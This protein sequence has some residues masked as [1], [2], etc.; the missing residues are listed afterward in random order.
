MATKAK[1]AN[2]CLFSGKPVRGRKARFL[3]GYDAKMKS[4]LLKVSRGQEKIAAVPKAALDALKTD[5]LLGFRYKDGQ[6]VAPKGTPK[7]KVVK[8][9]GKTKITKG[10]KKA[11]RVRNIQP[12]DEPSTEIKTA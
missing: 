1:A 3:P 4:L 12:E 11:K 2:L 7:L 6:I 8:G 10:A 5:G 9:A